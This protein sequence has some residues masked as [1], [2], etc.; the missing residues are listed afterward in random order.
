MKTIE[1]RFFFFWPIK[2]KLEKLTYPMWFWMAKVLLKTSES[3]SNIDHII[4]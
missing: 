1:Y 4:T 3:E 2:Y